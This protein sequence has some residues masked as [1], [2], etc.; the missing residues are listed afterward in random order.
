MHAVPRSC[1]L[2]NNSETA[3][4]AA[5]TAWKAKKK[6][7]VTGTNKQTHYREIKAVD[8]GHH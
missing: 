7:K 8:K 3:V 2:Y 5:N 1:Y 6:L 4:Y